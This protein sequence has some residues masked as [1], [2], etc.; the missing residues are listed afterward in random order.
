MP[1]L[2]RNFPR[3][4]FG[5]DSGLVKSRNGDNMGVNHFVY[6]SDRINDRHKTSKRAREC[7]SQLFSTAFSALQR[8]QSRN[9][10]KRV[11]T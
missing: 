2:T 3:I 11:E 10:N 5:N 4:S 7:V 6:V 1:S 8:A 9:I